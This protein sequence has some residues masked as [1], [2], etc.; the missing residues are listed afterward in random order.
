MD[1]EFRSNPLHWS[2]RKLLEWSSL[3]GNPITSESPTKE[4]NGLRNKLWE[5]YIKLQQQELADRKQLARELY[6]DGKSL[7]EIMKLCKANRKQL[8]TWMSE[9]DE[10]W[11]RRVLCPVLPDEGEPAKPAPIKPSE[12]EA[13]SVVTPEEDREL[14]TT[15]KDLRVE[16]RLMTVN[17]NEWMRLPLAEKQKAFE[18]KLLKHGMEILTHL[19]SLGD[20]EKAEAQNIKAFTALIT[21]REKLCP[22]QPDTSSAKPGSLHLLVMNGDALP[23]KAK[24]REIESEKSA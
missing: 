21:A 23:P 15:V 9:S 16:A 18:S 14:S 12:I 2:D 10:K 1:D 20:A 8:A 17:M 4:W 3:N 24:V 19:E 22:P 7:N 13:L 5:T 6:E 11:N